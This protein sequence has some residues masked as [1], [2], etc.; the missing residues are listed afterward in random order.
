MNL[1]QELLTNVQGSGGSRS[2]AKRQEPWRWA[3]WSATRSWQWPL[4]A[5]SKLILLQL[6]EKLPKN[7]TLTI[8]WPFSIGSKLERW[9]SSISG[10][11]MSWL[12]IKKKKNHCFEVSSSFI[13]HNNSEPPLYQIVKCNEKWVLY[14][15]QWWP[16]QWLNQEEASNHFPKHNL[17]KKRKVLVIVWWSAAGLSAS[18]ELPESQQNRYIWEVCSVNRWDAPKTAMPAA[19]TD[20]LKGPNSPWWHL[21]THR[22]TIISKVEHKFCIIHHI[23]QI[24]RQPTITSS[25]ILTTFCRENTSTTSR[26]QKMLSNISSN[27]KAQIFTLQE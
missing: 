18:L 27:P 8:L 12:Q 4:R 14:D 2:F 19:S 23:H 1:A 9:K 25:G 24:C 11:L 3:Q 22:T 5:S 26:R 16:A 6:R 21:T 20:Q 15:N 17:Y 10:C 7:S 13:L